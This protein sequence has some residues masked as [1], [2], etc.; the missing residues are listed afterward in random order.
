MRCLIRNLEN[1]HISRSWRKDAKKF[2]FSIDK[3]FEKVL[4]ACVE[5]HG[6]NWIGLLAPEF[7]KM[8]ENPN[9]G[10]QVHS[11]EVWQGDELV[12]GELGW[13]CGR[14]YTRYVNIYSI[15]QRIVV[16]FSRGS[17]F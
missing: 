6:M 4:A 12:A 10:V 15:S 9:H 17:L 3:A 5:E 8:F 11:T 7:Q 16:S 2:D 1:L 13:S 14:M